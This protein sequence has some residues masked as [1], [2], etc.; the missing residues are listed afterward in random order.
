MCGCERHHDDA[1]D[2]TCICSEHGNFS[3]AYDLAMTRYDQIV[4]LMKVNTRLI[5]TLDKMREI[6]ND[7]PS[8]EV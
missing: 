8:N 2:C 3:L 4:S 5:S 6:L 1:A 7:S